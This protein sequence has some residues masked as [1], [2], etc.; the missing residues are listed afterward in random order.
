MFG[1]KFKGVT[2]VDK[3]QGCSWTKL[4]IVVNSNNKV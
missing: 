4:R 3:E 1:V 2:S